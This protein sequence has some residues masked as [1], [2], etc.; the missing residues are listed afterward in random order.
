MSVP[1]NDLSINVLCRMG[2]AVVK[3]LGDDKLILYVLTKMI[4]TLRLVTEQT[5]K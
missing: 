5:I 3:K 2:E 1:S 4:A